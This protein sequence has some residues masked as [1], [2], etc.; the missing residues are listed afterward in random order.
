[1]HRRRA[2]AAACAEGTAAHQALAHGLP[3]NLVSRPGG[4]GSLNGPSHGHAVAALGASA[5]LRM[6]SGT[7]GATTLCSEQGAVALTFWAKRGTWNKRGSQESKH[8]EA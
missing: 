4:I 8:Y 7:G 5:N 1:M 6:F 3:T 2:D